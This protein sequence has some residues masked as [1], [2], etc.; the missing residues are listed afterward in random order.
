MYKK[1]H[2][3]KTSSHVLRIKIGY[4]KIQNKLEKCF[5]HSGSCSILQRCGLWVQ[6]PWPIFFLKRS[7]IDHG[8]YLHQ[9]LVPTM[10]GQLYEFSFSISIYPRPNFRI[11]FNSSYPTWLLL[12]TSSLAYPFSL[13]G[14]QLSYNLFPHSRHCWLTL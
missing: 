10:L 1:P 2:E 12:S 13:P 8:H 7:K 14:H 11:G 3:T 5:W 9:S 4:V 6:V